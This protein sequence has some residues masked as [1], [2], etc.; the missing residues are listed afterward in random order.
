MALQKQNKINR[1]KEMWI[2]TWQNRNRVAAIE[3]TEKTDAENKTT[4]TQSKVI[5]RKDCKLCVQCSQRDPVVV[6]LTTANN[7]KEQRNH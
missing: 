5:N 3:A 2:I 1:T 7:H 4:G 6:H